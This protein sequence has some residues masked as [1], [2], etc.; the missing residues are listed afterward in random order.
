MCQVSC[1]VRIICSAIEYSF[2]TRSWICCISKLSHGRWSNGLY[3]RQ[4]KNNFTP[5]LHNILMKRKGTAAIS[6]WFHRGKKKTWGGFRAVTRV[7]SCRCW[8]A[9]HKVNIAQ[10]KF[11]QTSNRSNERVAKFQLS[12]SIFKM[13]NSFFTCTSWKV[14]VTFINFRNL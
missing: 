4:R 9:E 14:D 7:R 3:I 5:D 13:G 8:Y 1:N 6:V 10:P 12:G 11:Y 2:N